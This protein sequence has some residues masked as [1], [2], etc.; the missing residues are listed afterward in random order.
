VGQNERLGNRYITDGPAVGFPQPTCCEFS[1]SS[2]GRSQLEPFEEITSVHSEPVL[3]DEWRP[4]SLTSGASQL[5]VGGG[6][7]EL[8]QTHI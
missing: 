1:G 7:R 2:L 5:Q 8:Y 4:T 6:Y 3:M